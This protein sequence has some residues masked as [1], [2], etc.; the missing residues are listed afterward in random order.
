MG[1]IQVADRA[2]T[3]NTVSASFPDSWYS[4]R[5]LVEPDCAPPPATN[6]HPLPRRELPPSP[7]RSLG[8]CLDYAGWP[9]CERFM[10]LDR[11]IQRQ[12]Q[13]GDKIDD[14]D[15][16][17]R[18]DEPRRSPDKA[19]LEWKIAGRINVFMKAEGCTNGS[20]RRL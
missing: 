17:A 2:S 4:G 7:Y 13:E 14:S 12:L 15:D 19:D 1:A 9:E 16:E 3:A 6:H 11:E 5:E 8:R 10:E 18:P 20:L